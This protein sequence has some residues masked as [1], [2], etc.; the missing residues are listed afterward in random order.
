MYSHR[1]FD[2]DNCLIIHLL[3]FNGSSD[4]PFVYLR[5]LKIETKIVFNSTI[6]AQ[7]FIPEMKKA[8]KTRNQVV[9]VVQC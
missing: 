5:E 6:T 8:E 9:V 7:N 1:E 4:C 2:S 3:V